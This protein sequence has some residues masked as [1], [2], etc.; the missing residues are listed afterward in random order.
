MESD[1][2]HHIT[3]HWWFYT[4]WSDGMLHQWAT[5]SIHATRI[6]WNIDHKVRAWI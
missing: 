4:H 5:W 3:D 2:L 6:H 1:F